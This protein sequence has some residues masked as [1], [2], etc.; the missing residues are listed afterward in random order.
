MKKL[1]AGFAI[2]VAAVGAV[3]GYRHRGGEEG[4]A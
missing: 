1:M 3:W 2:V 4:A